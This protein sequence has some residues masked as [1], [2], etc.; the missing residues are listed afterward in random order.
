L[1]WIGQ[2]IH[3]PKT[4]VKSRTNIGN[5]NVA[6]LDEGTGSDNR[7]PSSVA[8]HFI[9]TIPGEKNDRWVPTRTSCVAIGG[10]KQQDNQ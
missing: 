5:M 10:H 4:P 6:E 3:A 2:V 7:T 1:Q 9:A 8:A